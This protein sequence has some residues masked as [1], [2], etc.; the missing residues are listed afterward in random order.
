MTAPFAQG[1]LGRSYIGGFF[2]TLKQVRLHLL[3]L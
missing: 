1:G 2:D 3:F